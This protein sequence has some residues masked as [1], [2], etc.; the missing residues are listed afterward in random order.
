MKYTI[1]RT[2]AHSGSVLVRFRVHWLKSI[3]VNKTNGK[4]RHTA[5][6]HNVTKCLDRQHSQLASQPARHIRTHSHTAHQSYG[7][8]STFS[9]L[10]F[11]FAFL[12]FSHSVAHMQF[13]L[14]AFVCLLACPC[15]AVCCECA[16]CVW[17][18]V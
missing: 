8:N 9:F 3:N 1:M 11:Y 13:S 5:Q 12:R 18:R 7:S 14:F 6:Y 16:M 4:I 2:Q 15:S 17:L 10:L